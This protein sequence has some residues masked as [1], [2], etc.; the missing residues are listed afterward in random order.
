[1]GGVWTLWSARAILTILTCVSL[2]SLLMS[3]RLTTL[4][5]H[6][7]LAADVSRWREPSPLQ[8]GILSREPAAVL[9]PRPSHHHDP[10]LALLT[11]LERSYLQEAR[12]AAPLVLV[13]GQKLLVTRDLPTYVRA[14]TPAD[15]GHVR[16]S[17]HHPRRKTSPKRD[18]ADVA[19]RP[20]EEDAAALPPPPPPPP[21]TPPRLR[22]LDTTAHRVR[23]VGV[24]GSV[25]YAMEEEAMAGGQVAAHDWR[26]LVCLAYTD[27]D[28]SACLP[29][30]LFPALRPHQKVGRIPGLR[31]T[32]WR[33]ESLCEVLHASRLVP[34]IR[35]LVPAC[36][37]LPA[38]TGYLT[39]AAHALPDTAQWVIK[40][41]HSGKGVTVVDNRK[42]LEDLRDKRL[43]SGQV[44]QVHWAPPLQ[45][46]G[47]MV[48][49]RL[50]LLLT[51]LQPLR[52]HVHT[53]GEVVFRHP[54][55][56]GYA[57]DRVWM[58]S[59]LVSW[60]GRTSGEEAMRAMV[61]HTE[62]ALTTLALAA[63]LLLPPKF[64]N[65]RRAP[66]RYRCEGC[67][68]LLSVDLVYNSSFHPAIVGISGQ[69]DLSFSTTDSAG[70]SGHTTGR[71]QVAR[72]V[73]TLLTKD[74]Q[75]SHSV[76]EG[77]SEASDNLGV[78]GVDCL[79]S[80][81]LCL[82]EPDLKFLLDTRRE[83][84][85]SDYDQESGVSYVRASLDP[86]K[87]RH[88]QT[89]LSSKKN[90]FPLQESQTDR[91]EWLQAYDDLDQQNQRNSLEKK[92]LPTET[93]F[94]AQKLKRAGF[95][96]LYP[97]PVGQ[98]YDQVI[99]DLYH[100]VSS[101]TSIAFASAAFLLTESWRHM[102][103]DLHGL[104]TSLE[105]YY[106]PLPP[107]ISPMLAGLD[108]QPND[109][110]IQ[111]K[112]LKHQEDKRERCMQDPATAPY[113]Q[114]IILVPDISLTPSFTPLVT[115]YLAEVEYEVI[116]MQVTGVA[117]HCR[118]E[119]RLDDKFGP[120]NLVNYTLG[121]G[122][123]RI[124][125]AVVD[126]AHSEPWTLNTYTIHL[127]RRPPPV[128]HPDI[129]TEP[130]QVCVLK[131]ECE[132]RI[133]PSEPCSLSSESAFN[134]WKDFLSYSQHLRPC[135]QG[136]AHGRWV[137]PCSS[138]LERKDCDWSRAIWQPFSCTHYT[139]H[140][141]QLR[142]C[143][144][145]K[146]LVFLGDSTNRGMLYALLERLNGTLTSWDK[147]HDLRVIRGVN[148]GHTTFAFAYYPKFW[149]PSNQRPVFDQTLYQLLLRAGPL[150]NSSDTVVVV[151]GVH[152]VAAQHLHMVASALQ[153]EGLQGAQVIL[154]TLGV[155][156]HVAAPG[157][158]TVSLRDHSRLLDHSRYLAS[159]AHHHGYHV[160]DTFNMTAA[161]YRHF[162][163][164]KC[165][166]HFHQV[167][168]NRG[169]GGE[170]TYHVEGEINAVYTNILA[171]AICPHHVPTR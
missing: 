147:T 119:A 5:D 144:H 83:N 170:M 41:A 79:I 29:R 138:C 32:L 149:L 134:S 53:H 103:R 80:H 11:K 31:S 129:T 122:E 18:S 133:S 112:W 65:L 69:P 1:M 28:S 37:A 59:E 10:L 125:I 73:L 35:A 34:P 16:A 168:L 132:L 56:R 86:I 50:Y 4:Q 40:A 117:L 84:E 118:A 26:L 7:G 158:H 89:S 114:R 58:W 71:I 74:V 100:A 75:V 61:G 169:H 45:V 44:V 25:Y 161:R 156:F 97:S 116:T 6:V 101:N 8:R 81:E 21:P 148:K 131:Q 109:A 146:T 111:E 66:Q 22:L 154:K 72:D 110:D 128:P 120:S 52:A 163:Q 17:Q 94:T 140:T 68:Q 78:V 14:L 107:G 60:V 166:C 85:A 95:I 104:V 82:S 141:D 126:I 24:N 62:T 136:D 159:Y 151:G 51:S 47:V 19:A 121:L 92:Y 27:G 142:D 130:H 152:W 137:L 91:N 98:L 127:T 76:N 145:G 12:E 48:S 30:K 150:H 43:G 157:V 63:D 15:G 2:L 55:A 106:R 153:R 64:H 165:A 160:V 90:I 67:Y 96:M 57:K 13:R 93:K 39:A 70:H 38:H 139:I 135:Y 105:S 77:L 164:G 167:V 108:L 102:T 23:M 3:Y 33:Q 46:L 143:L 87:P 42:L 36:Y 162:L 9:L 115:S 113:L 49:V 123:N 88:E 20:E 54:P 155:G 171:N 124:P 99:S